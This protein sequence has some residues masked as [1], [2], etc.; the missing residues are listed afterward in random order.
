MRLSI[1][2]EFKIPIIYTEN[3]KDTANF[4]ILVAKRYEKSKTQNT[5]RQTKT[6]KTPEEQK[7][8]I[9]EGFPGIGPVVA[10]TLL[11]KYKTLNNIFKTT[12]EELKEI[13]KFDKNKIEKFLSLLRN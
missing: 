4:L 13:E 3:E 5:I 8:F 11:K 12:K 2:T 10:K 9:L 6:L 7:Q 1:A